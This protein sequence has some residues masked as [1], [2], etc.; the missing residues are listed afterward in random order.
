ML[1]RDQGFI[2][3]DPG[4]GS[5]YTEE[6]Q[7]NVS[8]WLSAGELVYREDITNG[9]DNALEGFV[10]MLQGK[11]FGKAALLVRHSV[12]LCRF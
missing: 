9:I 11:N 2:V 8:K 12:S 7:A 4:M 1:T 5:K 10:G 3:G 6:H